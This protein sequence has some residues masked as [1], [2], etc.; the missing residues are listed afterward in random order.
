MTGG[1]RGLAAD[2]LR[3][4]ARR[5]GYDIVRRRPGKSAAPL[6]ALSPTCQ[7]P[8]LGFL[9]ELF[10][11]NPE[12]GTFV[13][14]GA[15]DGETY[16]NSSCLADRGWRGVYVEP[17]PGFAEACR[18]RHAGNPRVSV[19]VAAIGS[20]PG[21]M[22]I[23]TGG[24]LS[25][26][27]PELAREYRETDWAKGE[28]ARAGEVR[29]PVVTL[30][31]LLQEQNIMPGFDVLGVDV[32]GLETAVFAGFDL[33]RWMPRMMIVELADTHPELTSTR[34]A[35]ASLSRDLARA[36]YVVVYKDAINAVFVQD[37]TYAGAYRLGT[38]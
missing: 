10:L 19:V 23:T 7:I 2:T 8:T 34:R 16:S 21:E 30:D 15:F 12:D 25:T 36:G 5:A 6:Y 26:A 20:A 35:H 22:T 33:A 29:V 24:P 31:Q 4:L 27:A 14:A 1:I 18:R 37:A 38:S 32:E 9:Y 11:G 17:V 3:M 13:E 28:F